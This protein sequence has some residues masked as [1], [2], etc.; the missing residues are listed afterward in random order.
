[1]T[2]APEII[3]YTNHICPWAHRAHIALAE[4]GLP[5]KEEIIDLS[6][7]RTDAYLK[8]NPRGLVPSLSYDGQILTESAVVSWFLADAHPSH[9]VPD[10]G[11]KEA[12]FARARISFFADTFINKV[13]TV[14]YKIYTVANDDEVAAVGH[15][16]VEAIVREIEP[17]LKD[18]APFF[19]GSE[20]L[21]QAEVCS[22]YTRIVFRSD[23]LPDTDT[24]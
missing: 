12:A 4:L 23:V 15:A 16:Q 13:A 6:T 5:F 8:V 11:S 22:C 10:T 1:M 19:G 2:T 14:G 3:L 9:L 7:P 18:A 24:C 21:T 17:L 20:K